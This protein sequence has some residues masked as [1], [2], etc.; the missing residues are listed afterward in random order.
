MR[1]TKTSNTHSFSDTKTRFSTSASASARVNHGVPNMRLPIL[2]YRCR[3]RH[4]VVMSPLH[5]LTLLRASSLLTCI[6]ALSSPRPAHPPTRCYADLHRAKQIRRC[7]S[8]WRKALRLVDEIA[9]DAAHS[10]CSVEA[11]IDACARAGQLDAGLRLFDA[12]V[13][14]LGRT[15]VTTSTTTTT[16]WFGRPRWMHRRRPSCRW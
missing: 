12:Y 4:A 16:A 5:R 6:A 3:V 9:D 8:D 15:A 13:E 2:P 11:A 1:K 10:S 14:R 7:G